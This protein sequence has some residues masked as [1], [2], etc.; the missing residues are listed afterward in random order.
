M[1]VFSIV[2]CTMYAIVCIIMAIAGFFIIDDVP[3]YKR[4][5]FGIFAGA[6]G[7]VIWSAL[8]ISMEEK[9]ENIVQV[10]KYVDN[11]ISNM[12]FFKFE[13]TLVA[14]DTW[15]LTESGQKIPITGE[16]KTEIGLLTNKY[17][18]KKL[19]RTSYF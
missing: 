12:N 16:F 14:E 15:L 6:V 2:I 4:F 19:D 5:V 10:T 9:M 3:L 8:F 1:E 18:Q 11:K 13:K 7:P 17:I